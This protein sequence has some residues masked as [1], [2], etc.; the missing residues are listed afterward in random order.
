MRRGAR[1]VQIREKNVRDVEMQDARYDGA[2]Q[3]FRD[4][5][6]GATVA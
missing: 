5:S 1:G 6:N 4:M 3:P 2:S